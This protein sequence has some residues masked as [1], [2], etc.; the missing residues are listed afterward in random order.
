MDNKYNKYPWYPVN[1]LPNAFDTS[2][3]IEKELSKQQIHL[4]IYILN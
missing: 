4:K 2:L 1:P 3:I